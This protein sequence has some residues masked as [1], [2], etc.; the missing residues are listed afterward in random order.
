MIA[1]IIKTKYFHKITYDLKCHFYAMEKF[2]Y[3]L[4]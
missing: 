1:N 4:L 3:S 2:Y